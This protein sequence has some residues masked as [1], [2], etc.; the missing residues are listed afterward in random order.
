MD[1]DEDPDY[2]DL[3]NIMVQ[4]KM[5]NCKLLVDI[6]NLAFLSAELVEP[7]TQG[8]TFTIPFWMAKTLYT[9]SIVDI[10]LPHE[11]TEASYGTMEPD[12]INV[13]LRK[14][15]PYFYQ[16]GQM[17]LN[18]RREKGNNLAA[19]T[20]EG[21][22]N[23]YRREEGETLEDRRRIAH[24]LMSMFHSRRTQILDDSLNNSKEDSQRVK[25]FKNK[26]DNLEI[27]LFRLGRQKE[28]EWNVWN[29]TTNDRVTSSKVATQITKRQKIQMNRENKTNTN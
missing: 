22:R 7:R 16:L 17:L 12:P 18:L 26:L 27:K 10:E 13:D 2:L 29:S 3:E 1:Y 5:I 20:E 21:Q 14:K 15:G 8:R 23:K 4:T 28:I 19:Y 9:Y 25:E 24:F 6:P 11:Y